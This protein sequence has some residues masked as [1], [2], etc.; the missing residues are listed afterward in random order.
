MSLPIAIYLHL[1]ADRSR[2][3]D[4]VRLALDVL[5]GVPSIVYGAFGFIILLWFFLKNV[6]RRL[7]LP[8]PKP[9]PGKLISR[10]LK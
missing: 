10:R 8:A 9:R 1:Y 2:I 7:Y 4:L 3:V 5:W 6:T